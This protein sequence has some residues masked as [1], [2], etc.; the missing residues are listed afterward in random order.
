MS[1]VKRWTT[2][3]LLPPDFVAEIE[4]CAVFGSSGSEVL[5]ITKDDEVYGLGTNF[6]SCLGA[7][8]ISTL[9]P[10]RIEC[11]SGKRI[12]QISFGSG[13]HVIALSEVGSVYS[14]GHNAFG[15]LGLGHSLQGT[16]PTLIAGI[17]KNEK[18]T[19]ISCGGHHSVAI[20][21]KGEVFT[22]GMNSSG[23]LGL[24]DTNNQDTPKMVPLYNRL[25]ISAACG[26]NSTV[27]LSQSGDVYAWGFNGNGQ[28]GSGCT[29]N[30]LIPF[31]IESLSKS[32]P[33]IQIVCG[34]AHTLALSD[35]GKLYVWGS[36]SCGQLGNHNLRKNV[37]EPIQ[38]AEDLGLIT[39]VGAVHS[40]NVTAV[41]NKNGKVF[42]W[43]HLRGQTVSVPIETR[44]RRV[45]D[46]FSCFASPAVS[47]RMLYFQ[48]SRQKTI[49]DSLKVAF[50]DPIS[51]DLVISVEGNR[52][53]V[54]K[55]L[56]K[57][58]CEYFKTRLGGLWEENNG[59]IIEVKDFPFSIYKSF[60]FWVYTDELTV[61]GVED[62]VGLLELSN[63]YCET[64]LKTKCAN[65][66]E[67]VISIENAAQLYAISL[68]YNVHTLEE[69][70]FR[71][72]MN[73]MT[74]VTQSE[75]FRVLDDFS[76]KQLISRA[77]REGV[78]K[79]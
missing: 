43:G 10:I 9:N 54:H 32:G 71:F 33:I 57:I 58:R 30:Q 47:F 23:Q 6:C 49:L 11:L 40:C 44:F 67:K 25:I 66:L 24:G 42:M 31:H 26:H 2:L 14:W 55:S 19:F 34:Y 4:S 51:S 21:E 37:G 15:Q 28:I 76:L 74:A 65:F 64:V 50:D 13:P 1:D 59:N 20:S 62:A 17:L 78:F 46:C 48:N 69:H 56:L 68:K 61:D 38:T 75:S 7:P 3:S 63:C 18:I 60:L 53:H 72:C 79:R 52:I 22:W 45:D 36:N 39:E 16:S 73:H 12:R 8:S 77:S 41:S 35:Q 70:C 27:V 5:M 29:Y